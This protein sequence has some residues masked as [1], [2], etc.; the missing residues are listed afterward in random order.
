MT[1]KIRVEKSCQ[2]EYYAKM[3]EAPTQETDGTHNVWCLEIFVFV[4]VFRLNMW[5]AAV[6][7]GGYLW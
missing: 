7:G 1:E 6:G 4:K 5:S 3:M 2:K